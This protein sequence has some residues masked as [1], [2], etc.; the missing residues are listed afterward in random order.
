MSIIT[1]ISI[2]SIILSIGSVSFTAYM[3]GLLNQKLTKEKKEDKIDLELYQKWLKFKSL[4]RIDRL[5]AA[6]ANAERKNL[7]HISNSGT[8]KLLIVVVAII[9]TFVIGANAICMLCVCCPNV[10][11][12]FFPQYASTEM[13]ISNPE[14]EGLSDENSSA[15]KMEAAFISTGLNI[16]AIAIAVWSGLHIIQVLEKNQFEESKI[17]LE[18]LKNE[19]EK[20]NEERRETSFKSFLHSIE[21]LGANGEHDA[22]NIYITKSF[23]EIDY[24]SL[25]ADFVF[26]LSRIEFFFR[27]IYT[28][29]Y[30]NDN[31]SREEYDSVIALIHDTQSKAEEVNW[32]SQKTKEV[33]ERYLQL[34]IAEINFYYG[35]CC[36]SYKAYEVYQEAIKCY[37]DIFP[38][39]K[40]PENI[41][42]RNKNSE[43]NTVF[44]AYMLNTL[45]GSYSKI[46][47]RCKQLTVEEL[48][49]C[50]AKGKRYYDALNTI[51]TSGKNPT[52]IQ[53]EVYYRNRGCFLERYCG[54]D[55][56][57]GYPS[58]VEYEEIMLHYEKALAIGLKEGIKERQFY[59]FF[60]LHHKYYDG[61]YRIGSYSGKVKSFPSPVLGINPNAD[62]LLDQL[63]KCSAYM[64][65]ALIFGQ[66]PMYY[67]KQQA[68]L[69]RDYHVVYKWKSDKQKAKEFR[70][71]MGEAIDFILNIE[72]KHDDFVYQ[73]CKQFD[74]LTSSNKYREVYAEEDKKWTQKS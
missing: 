29:H 30:S 23:S 40:C 41:A 49:D 2:F 51:L 22:L 19:V 44:D 3:C 71:K 57:S 20:S 24:H 10:V 5:K 13:L 74:D 11:T 39:F 69:Y 62:K 59:V 55:G 46:L 35:Y 31:I 52:E 32:K 28:K 27:Q 21:I 26:D 53:R 6:R 48:E 17:L 34:R 37:L 7:K 38:E 4:R 12:N 47:H 66:N 42:N 8:Q 67:L 60:S 25:S 73:L 43:D 61:L 72:V 50:K 14:D 68:F 33:V 58:D 9:T 54:V 56:D 16:I 36:A 63:K 1:V 70:A 45:G 15:L 64:E 65:I 18:R